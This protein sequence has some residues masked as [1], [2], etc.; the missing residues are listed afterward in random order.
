MNRA[1][2]VVLVLAAV[3]ALASLAAWGAA[4]WFLGPRVLWAPEGVAVTAE[5]P[6]G[7]GV[8]DGVELTIRIAN[9]GPGDRRLE[10]IELADAYLQAFA[11]ERVEPTP[12]DT[13]QLTRYRRYEFD[14]PVPA[15]GTTLVRFTLRA[16][17]PGAPAG[18]VHVMF[19]DEPRIAL[20]SVRTAVAAR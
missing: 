1:V 4:V 14:H 18:R 16:L 11:V 19:D 7:V 17:G 6:A 5:A 15:G 3:L 8:G 9:E 12:K 20:T 2:Q 10:A 13:S